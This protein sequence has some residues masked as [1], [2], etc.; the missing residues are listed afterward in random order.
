M[1][2]GPVNQFELLIYGH[3]NLN[4]YLK[5]FCKVGMLFEQILFVTFCNNFIF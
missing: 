3:Q 5:I 4:I 2:K 1:N